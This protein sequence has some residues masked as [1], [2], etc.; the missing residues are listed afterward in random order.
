MAH[1]FRR[2]SHDPGRANAL[3]FLHSPGE[4]VEPVVMLVLVVVVV[5]T[6]AAA[7]AGGDGDGGVVL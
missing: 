5:C 3:D 4:E 6:P 1:A 2:D 7:S